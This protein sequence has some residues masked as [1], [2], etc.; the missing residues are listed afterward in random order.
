MKRK[1]YF[2]FIGFLFLTLP[3]NS[4]SQQEELKALLK[5]KTT[6]KEITGTFEQYLKTMPGS[7]EKKKLEK[8]FTRWAY[9]QSLHLGPGGEF[10]NISKK[11]LEAVAAKTN[12]PQP[13]SPT[14][15]ANGAWYLVGP[16]SSSNNNPTASGNGLGRVDRIAFHPSNA[17]I[18]YLG[19]PAGGLWKTTDGGSTWTALSSFIPSLGISG[20]V[21]DWTDPNTIYVLTGDGDSHVATYFE[22][23]SGYIRLS[24]GVMVS[25]DAGL[26]WEETGPLANDDFVGYKLIQHPSNHLILLAATSDGIYRTTNGGVSWVR[27]R[28]GL[29]YDVE[30]KPGTPSKVYAADSSFFYYSNDTGDTWNYNSTF[31]PAGLCNKGRIEIGV[32]PNSVNRVFLLAGPKVGAGFCGFFESTNSGADFTRLCNSPNILGDE[33]GSGNQ[34]KYDIC[35]AIK[36][37]NYQVIVVGGLCTYKSLNGGDTFNWLTSYWESGGKYIHPDVHSVAYNPLNNY[38][39]AATDGGFYSST[40]DGANWTNLSAGISTA[41]FYHIDDYNANQYAMLG[42]CQDNGIKY[43]TANTSAFSHISSG[44]GFDAVIDYTNQAKGYVSVNEYLLKY[45]NFTGSP[46][47]TIA[48]TGSF[49]KQIEMN[50]SN[51][52]FIYF[53]RDSLIL[54]YDTSTDISTRLGTIAR[55]HWALK[56]CPSNSNRIYAA[57]GGASFDTTG[58]MFTTA[59][60]GTTWDTISDQ[61]GFPASFPRISDIGVSPLNSSYVYTCFSGYTDGLKVLYSSSSGQQWFNLSYNLPDIPVWSI[62]VDAGNNL[63]VGTDFGVYYKAS[64]INHWEPFYNGLPNVPVSDLAINESADQILAATFGRGIWKSTLR[65]SCPASVYI[66]DTISG[67]FFRSASSVITVS[68]PVAGGVGTSAVLRSPGHIDLWP[69][70]QADADPGNKFLAYIGPC[71]SGLPPVFAPAGQGGNTDQEVYE[72]NMTRNAGTL[73]V[74]GSKGS[75]QLVLRQFEDGPVRVVLTDNDGFFIRDIVNT[76]RQKGESTYDLNNLNLK[77]GLYFLYLAVNKKITHLQELEIQ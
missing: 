45:N 56:T 34:T 19:T 2:F 3:Y 33:T 4:Y 28:A 47:R 6:Y 59:D 12:S 73:E 64:G 61:P 10:V 69:G 49:F 35:I 62:E 17:N 13:N 55:G 9:Y 16:E 40:N 5:G 67:R 38:L 1:I 48:S 44:D 21:V 66:M 24:V 58:Q 43:K 11:T 77:P 65:T 29:C 53:T 41:Q 37:T 26:T 23:L 76:D 75:K 15:T 54:K 72:M 25:H 27:E 14:A 20:I 51:S 63:Y 50:S 8:H 39:Y 60:G 52:K 68:G 42:G 36:P 46:Y 31:T 30:F 22:V 71:D 7:P 32:T 18:I 57:G 70:F 74:T